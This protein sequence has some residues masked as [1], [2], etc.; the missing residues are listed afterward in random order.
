MLK[1]DNYFQDFLRIFQLY[2]LLINPFTIIFIF[3]FHKTKQKQ[4]ND[5][6]PCKQQQE[7]SSSTTKIT[8]KQ[9]HEPQHI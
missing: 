4:T 9:I 3:S 1:K 5:K 2:I 7:Q 8:T 6:K